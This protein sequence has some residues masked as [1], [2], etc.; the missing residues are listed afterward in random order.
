LALPREY[1]ELDEVNV[2]M[3][4]PG[5]PKVVRGVVLGFSTALGLVAGT[6]P[7]RRLI[8]KAVGA[9]AR[10]T[11][12]GPS[13]ESRETSGTLVAAVCQGAQGAT[14]SSTLLSGDA[15]GYT[16]TGRT[17]AWG[18]ASIRAGEQKAAGAVGPVEAFGLEECLAA[19]S[20]AGL[21]AE[22]LPAE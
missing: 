5:P 18:A 22:D 6:G 17:L 2:Y 11:G 19:L 10:T 7:G 20:K 9:A 15:N 8:E 12:G 4:W 14:V 21:D 3:E 13:A 16:L 1:P